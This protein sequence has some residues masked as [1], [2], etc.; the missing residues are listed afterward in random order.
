MRHWCSIRAIVL[1]ATEGRVMHLAVGLAFA[2]IALLSSIQPAKSA[3]AAIC[4]AYARESASKAQGVRDFA[5]GYD[6][7]DPRWTT[8]RKSHASWC[9]ANPE[10]TVADET[11]R[12]R[13]EIK[14]CSECRAYANYAVKSAAENDKLRCGFSGP[15]WNAAAAD[16]FGWCMALRGGESATNT[17][18]AATYK[19]IAEKIEKSTHSET[20]ERITQIATCKAPKPK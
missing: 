16:H 2:V 8:D 19:A 14:L 12:R 4:D 7:K 10:K 1:A 6:L 11:A 13:G 9:W 20:L 18:I 17:N 3:S 5:C 15:R